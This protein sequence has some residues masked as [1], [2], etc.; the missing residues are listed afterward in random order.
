MASVHDVAA[1]I[2][3]K[4]APMS[5]WK[6]QK[7]VY[8]SQAWRIAWY[9]RPLFDE[10][11]QAWANGPVVPAL[12]KEHR[13]QFSVDGWEHGDSGALSKIEGKTIDA[14]LRA[15]GDMTGRQLSQLTH[16]ET[17]WRDARGDL[18]PTERSDEE[19]THSSLLAFYSALD[20]DENAQPVE[21]IDW[22]AL[23]S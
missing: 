12:Y 4:Q 9:E 10:P 2:L 13:G 17:P 3:E 5:T 18:D 20:V 8:Y 16:S 7:L 14:V 1:Y 19:I 22:D 6:L 21:Q 11:I 15:Y 23:D